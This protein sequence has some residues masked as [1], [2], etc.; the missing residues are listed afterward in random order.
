MITNQHPKRQA[1]D[2]HLL[3]QVKILI[4]VVQPPLE[5]AA[6]RRGRRGAVLAQGRRPAPDPEP[7]LLGQELVRPETYLKLDPN[8]GSVP[9]DHLANGW[10]PLKTS[11]IDVSSKSI[12]IPLALM[13]AF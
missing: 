5:Q 9:R 2:A 3:K 10:L 1:T 11:P 6:A 4:M 7:A 12:D 8:N 13:F